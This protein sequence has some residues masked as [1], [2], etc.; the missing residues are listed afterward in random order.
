MGN[1]PLPDPVRVK[2]SSEAAEYVSL[3]P[4]VVQSMALIELLEHVAG[5][6]GIDE[7][8]AAQILRS[9][10]LVSGGSRLRWEAIVA[11]P[12]ELKDAFRLLP[13]P[14]P[15]RE[16]AAERCVHFVLGGPS[17]RIEIPKPAAAEKRFLRRESFWDALVAIAHQQAPVY[18]GYFYRERADRY[19][20]PLTPDDRLALRAAGPR[21]KYRNLVRQIGVAQ[22]DWVEFFVPR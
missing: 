21:L 16:F 3:T 5:V 20:M 6:A 18:A 17:A 4:V 22:L 7:A 1:M 11:E 13:A 2:I 19:R 8:R 14:D 15:S 12:A 10:S 9:G